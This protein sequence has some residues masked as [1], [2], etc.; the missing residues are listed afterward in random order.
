MNFHDDC[1]CC[2]HRVAAYTIQ[3]N[4]PLARAFL[5]FAHAALRAKGAGVPKSGFP[6]G[7]VQYTNFQKLRHFGLIQQAEKGREWHMTKLGLEFAAGRAKVLTPAATL[8]GEALPPD[9]LAWATHT[10]RRAEVGIQDVLPD[11]WKPREE[12]AA[13]KR[14]AVA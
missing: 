4:K 12:Y 9:H 10:K 7:N 11:E 13:E 5:S 14:D 6:L 8:R 3:L 2:G 1:P